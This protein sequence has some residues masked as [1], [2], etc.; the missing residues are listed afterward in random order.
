MARRE[1]NNRDHVDRRSSSFYT[2]IDPCRNG[3]RGQFYETGFESKVGFAGGKPLGE[4]PQ[5]LIPF[6]NTASMPYE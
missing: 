6:L 3:R 4:I 1:Q 5:F 2:V